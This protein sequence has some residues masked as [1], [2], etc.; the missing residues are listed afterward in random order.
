M[1]PV[2]PRLIAETL[3]RTDMDRYLASLV[4]GERERHA[5]QAVWAFGAE[6]A[7]IPAR[8]T[9][10][11]PGEIR[12]Q[13]WHDALTGEEH[14]AV[15][16]NPLAAALLDAIAAYDLPTGPLVR[17]IEARR[18]DLYQDPMPDQETFE[19][20][21]GETASILYALAA[22][23]LAKG[24]LVNSA[25]AAG[26]MGVAHALIGHLRAFGYNAARARIFLPKSI[27]DANGVTEAALF[28]G[29][30]NSALAAASVQFRDLARAHLLQAADAFATLPAPVRPAFAQFPILAHQLDALDRFAETPLQTPPDWP[31]WRKIAAILG[32]SV[33]MAT[34]RMRPA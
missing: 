3:K 15:R 31:D 27:L 19:G 20:Y 18:F 14:G 13:W 1:P 30:S 2:D 22:T 23:I 29:Q 34:T 21:A 12:L 28:A 7:S 4:L 33:R 8:V 10:P 9:E 11:G 26:H 17:L 16:Q 24:A 25:D 5:V 6:I 32:W